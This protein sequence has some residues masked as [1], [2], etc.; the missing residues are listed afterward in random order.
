MKRFLLEYVP[1]WLLLA[2]LG[3]IVI[4]APMTVWISAHAPGMALAA[5]AWKELLSALAALLTGIALWKN[6]MLANFLRR[7]LVLL[8][9][10]YTALHIIMCGVYPQPGVA[11]AA[12]LLINLRY[13]LY[14]VTVMGFLYLYPR[15]KQSFI[16]IGAVGAAIVVG[17]AVLQLFIPKETLSL[18]GYG[19]STIEPYMTVDKNPDFIRHNSTLRGPNPLGAYAVMVL[20]AVGAYVASHRQQLKT[21]RQRTLPIGLLVAGMVALWISYSRSA[22]IGAVLALAVVAAWKFRLRLT[23]KNWLVLGAVVITCAAGLLLAKDTYFVQNVILHNNPTTGATIDSNTAHAD[24]LAQGWQRL[25]LQP[26]GAGVGSTGSASLIGGDGTIIENAYLMVAHESG[27]IGLVLFIAIFVTAMKQ[28][29][30]RRGDWLA[31]GLF[32]SGIGLAVIGLMLP[33]WA[34]DT[35]SL[36]WWGLAATAITGGNNG[37]DTPNK[38]AKRT[39]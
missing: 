12:G 32:A 1:A 13:I 28:L 16:R 6:G 9:L 33:V 31:L 17:F 39:A 14:F 21:W 25:V 10:A 15:Y 27:W 11:V 29:W 24:S 22:L 4:H 36:V 35:V 20:A 5:K 30:Q 18:L 2:V 8:A 34:D 38:K 7:P 26:L 37:L 23:R 3:F 19:H